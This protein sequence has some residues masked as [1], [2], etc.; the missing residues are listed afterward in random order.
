MEFSQRVFFSF[1]TNIVQL[2]IATHY[3]TVRLASTRVCAYHQNSLSLFRPQHITLLSRTPRACCFSAVRA[4]RLVS[5]RRVAVLSW[6]LFLCFSRF[7][8]LF[9]RVAL[10][11]RSSC[12][13]CSCT[14][15]GDI[16]HKY[17]RVSLSIVFSVFVFIYNIC[18]SAPIFRPTSA[19][20]VLRSGPIGAARP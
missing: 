6:L 19:R 3:R 1:N 9:G 14:S 4:A 10:S 16:L 8:V 17:F 13:I 11:S 18:F 7:R 2:R 5:G 20:F 15:A 12:E